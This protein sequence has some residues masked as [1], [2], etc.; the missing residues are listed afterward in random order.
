[1]RA[2]SFPSA[3]SECFKRKINLDQFDKHSGMKEVLVSNCVNKQR[4]VTLSS[5][6][7]TPLKVTVCVYVWMY[8][9]IRNSQLVFFFCTPL[10][11]TANMQMTPCWRH[12]GRRSYNLTHSQGANNELVCLI[13][14]F[15]ARNKQ[16]GELAAIK[17][18]KM[19]PGGSC[20]VYF[21]TFTEM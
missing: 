4:E 16:N 9:W 12:T 11:W 2:G 8:F 3:C 19:E 1:M 18:I 20:N 5:H 21:T 7:I 14:C 10:I 6:G 15:Q 13:L 17:V